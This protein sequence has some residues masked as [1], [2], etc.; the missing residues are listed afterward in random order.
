MQLFPSQSAITDG[1]QAGSG[2]A[3]TLKAERNTLAHWI[4][5]PSC[6]GFC[7]FVGRDVLESIEIWP[8]E[9]S[10]GMSHFKGEPQTLSVSVTLSLFV[11]S[12]SLFSVL[13]TFPRG[14]STV[15]GLFGVD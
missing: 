14:L 13:L 5:I 10:R 7:T 15:L 2:L 1:A 11:L 4:F 12:L 6:I 8:I 9:S 3:L